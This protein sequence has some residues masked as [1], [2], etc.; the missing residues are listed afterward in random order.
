LPKNRKL[1]VCR[2]SAPRTQVSR[3]CITW[4]TP[5]FI[6]IIIIDSSPI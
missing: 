1:P 4:P 5:E 3:G 2:Q 6:E